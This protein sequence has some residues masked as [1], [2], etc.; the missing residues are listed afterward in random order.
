MLTFLRISN[1]QNIEKD[2]V[3]KYLKEAPYCNK[4]YSYYNT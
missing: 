4:Y 1:R 2:I 3:L